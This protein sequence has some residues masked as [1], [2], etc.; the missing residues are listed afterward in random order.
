M[1][2]PDRFIEDEFPEP[3]P[4]IPVVIPLPED[5]PG[6]TPAPAGTPLGQPAGVSTPGPPAVGPLGWAP[7]PRVLNPAV[8]GGSV[9]G[10]PEVIDPARKDLLKAGEFDAFV[11]IVR[12][13]DYT[14]AHATLGMKQG[15]TVERVDVR[16]DATTNKPLGTVT[17]SPGVGSTNIVDC[18]PWPGRHDQELYH[19]KEGDIVSV[20]RGAD[21]LHWFMVDDLPFVG[22]VVA[23]EDG[24]ISEEFSGGADSAVAISGLKVRQQAMTGDPSSEIATF[25]DLETIAEAWVTGTDYIIDGIVLESTKTYRCKEAHTA[26][27]FATNLTDGKWE[28]DNIVIYRYVNVIKTDNMTHGYRVGDKVFVQRRGSYLFALPAR[29]QFLA[30]TCVGTNPGP[31]NAADFADEH[32][33][34]REVDPLID[35]Y[36]GDAWTWLNVNARTQTDPTGSGGQ[37]GR[38]IDAVNLAE[39]AGGS[40][41]LDTDI[42]VMVTMW[43]DVGDYPYYTFDHAV[44]VVDTNTDIYAK[45]SSSDT[46]ADYLSN[47]ITTSGSWLDS[48][49]VNGAG[50]E[51]LNITHIGPLQSI[52]GWYIEISGLTGTIQETSSTCQDAIVG[53]RQD[54]K[55]HT[56]AYNN[57][58]SSPCWKMWPDGAP[59]YP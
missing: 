32:Y 23:W 29:Q 53:I 26:G 41:L 7:A 38:W 8:G 46:T 44:P 13:V 34:L 42:L 40:H 45:V 59:N 47:K 14:A 54:V 10:G 39:R 48:N 19:V 3:D 2:K 24:Y 31:S 6:V 52:A 43:A 1:T 51:E 25:A 9:L 22:V 56:F 16:W 17:P 36:A 58:M 12:T 21:G 28:E 50:D 27:T 20:L 35:A 18:K 33:W 15:I 5:V 37:S 4:L 30:L 49:I 11:G 57:C 55:G